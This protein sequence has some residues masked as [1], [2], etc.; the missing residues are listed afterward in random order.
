[1]SASSRSRSGKSRASSA[2]SARPTYASSGAT[3]AIATARSASLAIPSPLTSLVETTAWRLPTNTRR[4][5]SS[6]SERSDS[7]TR[8]SRTSTPCD[9]PRTA[10]ASAAS[11]PAR[12]AASTSAC[13]RSPSP[14]WSSRS[15]LAAA[16]DDDA[17]GEEF[18]NTIPKLGHNPGPDTNGPNTDVPAARGLQA[19]RQG[20]NGKLWRVRQRLVNHPHQALVNHAGRCRA[21]DFRLTSLLKRIRT[22]LWQALAHRPGT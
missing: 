14:D 19:V 5:T 16:A 18:T 12:R 15:E 2:G 6:P 9:T 20:R 22:A 4:P 8:P 21:S 13:A 3:R 10:T 7:S 1:M 11:A 17:S